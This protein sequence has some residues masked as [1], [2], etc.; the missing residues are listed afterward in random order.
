MSRFFAVSQFSQVRYGCNYVN[1]TCL[2]FGDEEIAGGLTQGYQ[3]C[4]SRCEI[5]SVR[6][7][8]LEGPRRS[9]SLFLTTSQ[10]FI[11]EYMK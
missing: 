7:V 3:M 11:P 1:F 6:Q 9:G 10:S 2:G 8:L 4:G 5:S